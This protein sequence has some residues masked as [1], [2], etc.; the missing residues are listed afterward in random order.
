MQEWA[1]EGFFAL[2]STDGDSD[3]PL[4]SDE[5]GEWLRGDVLGILAAT[6]LGIS[7]VATPVSC[8]TALEKCNRFKKICR[9]RIGSPYV[10]EGMESL[11]QDFN[12][13]AGY[14]ANGGFLLQT[15]VEKAGKILKALP[16]RDA[17]LP[18]IS[19]LV[20]AKNL[21]IKVSDLLKELPSRFSASDRLKN[22]PTE[23]SKQKIAEIKSENLGEVLFGKF[24]GKLKSIDETDGF[25]M[26]FD[27]EEIIHLRPSGNAPELRCYVEATSQERA[28]KLLTDC[29]QVLESFR[30]E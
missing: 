9:T 23:R 28:K 5:N 17:L 11:A 20:N 18:I 4:L 16:T 3:R 26:T 2:V 15:D 7:S 10:I 6:A 22:F 27:S 1:K 8:N 29:I 21:K 24:S 14:E 12:S 30:G 25:R 19:V 13:I